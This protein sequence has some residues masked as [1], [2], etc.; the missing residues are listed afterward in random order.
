[1][2]LYSRGRMAFTLI[3]LLVV[4]AM[5]AIL[6]SLLV[7]AVQK[8]R[9]AAARMT[10]SNNLKQLALAAHN[11]HDA[12]RRLPYCG[13]GG[14]TASRLGGNL[15]SQNWADDHSWFTE[16]L[17]YI[18]QYNIFLLAD[19]TFRINGW[20]D[21]NQQTISTI[22]I[23][24]HDCPLDQQLIRE[25][26]AALWRL[27]TTNYVCNVGN[28]TY[29]GRD[30]S[31]PTSSPAVVFGGAPFD[32]GVAVTLMSIT[33]GTSNTV[34]FSELVV[35]TSN[36]SAWH[37]P[38]G[39]V[40]YQSGAGFNTFFPPNSMEPDRLARNRYPAG[41]LGGRFKS[42]AGIPPVVQGGGDPME[43]QIVNAR[44][45]H[46]GGVNASMCDGS[47]RFVSE[48]IDVDVWRAIGT[49]RGGETLTID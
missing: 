38:T 8:V 20:T 12:K 24:T 48:S 1:M 47:V 29:L 27:R 13:L 6:I 42:I 10:C 41:S 5:I 43:W 39:L 4:I 34:M 28:T 9:E 2:I 46:I 7:P 16:T 22:G 44:S 19:L 35:P 33:D 11:H 30:F 40:R 3:E 26:G 17:P 23:A 32:F 21:T 18:E 15:S 49:S 45:F 36:P 37:G 31:Y 14:R 25:D